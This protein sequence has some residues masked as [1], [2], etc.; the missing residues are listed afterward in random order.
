MSKIS[1]YAKE[2]ALSVDEVRPAK[3]LSPGV[4]EKV[5]Q[6]SEKQLQ[7]ALL[8]VQDLE[9]EVNEAAEAFDKANKDGQKA[10][11]KYKDAEKAVSEWKSLKSKVDVAKNRL[12]DAEKEMSTGDDNEKKRLVK[13]LKVQISQYTAS[14]ESSLLH[15]D[16]WMKANLLLAGIKL[17][18][19]AV[20][21][22]KSKLE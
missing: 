18:E 11:S 6:D 8:E 7:A 12:R 13:S 14:L 17:N 21:E 2:P 4:D 10:L 5:K 1:R 3:M 9:P 19:E 22:K 16:E 20:F 15:C